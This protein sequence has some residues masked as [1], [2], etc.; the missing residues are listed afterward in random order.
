M[1]ECITKMHDKVDICTDEHAEITSRFID[2]VI[3]NSLNFACTEYSGADTDKCSTLK[4]P[5]K[6]KNQRRPKSM[7]IAFLKLF[8]TLPESEKVIK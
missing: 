4:V 7:I 8:E 3:G 5:K 1:K 6:R 2:S